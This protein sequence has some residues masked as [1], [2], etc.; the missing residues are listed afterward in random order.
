MSN[1]R[2]LDYVTL[3]IGQVFYSIFYSGKWF[4]T[5]PME[6]TGF[7]IY[8]EKDEIKVRYGFNYVHNGAIEC[9]DH[10]LLFTTEEEALKG[11]A[12]RNTHGK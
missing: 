12:R 7:H 8:R 1:K 6:V 9:P 11:C 3:E 5:K 10:N 4:V 2:A